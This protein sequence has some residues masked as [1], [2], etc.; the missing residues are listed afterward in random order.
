MHIL[1]FVLLLILF[2]CI[3]V[4]LF[5]AICLD[6]SFVYTVLE[7]VQFY[8][9]LALFEQNNNVLIIAS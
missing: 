9:T 1:T 4:A 6:L 5:I 7:F 8:Y 3:T 2:S